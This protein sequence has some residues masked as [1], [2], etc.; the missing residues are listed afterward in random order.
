MSRCSFS[1]V[2]MVVQKIKVHPFFLLKIKFCLTVN[3]RSCIT[4]CE[5]QRNIDW[6]AL[7]LIAKKESELCSKLG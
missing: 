4:K 5:T 7:A 1:V 6:A 3:S 2:I